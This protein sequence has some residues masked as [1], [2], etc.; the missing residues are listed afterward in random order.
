[1]PLTQDLWLHRDARLSE[2]DWKP[3]CRADYS[4]PP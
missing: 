1:M 4:G 3:V 2:A